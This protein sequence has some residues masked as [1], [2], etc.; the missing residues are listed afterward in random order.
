MA[1]MVTAIIVL[2]YMILTWA[3]ILDNPTPLPN[4]NKVYMGNVLTHRNL[5]FLSFV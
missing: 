5:G 3:L 2:N 1:T 4:F